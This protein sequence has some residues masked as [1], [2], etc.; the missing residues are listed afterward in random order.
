[1][2]SSWIFHYEFLSSRGN[3]EDFMMIMMMINNL[4]ILNCKLKRGKNSRAEFI[5][6]P[7]LAE[8]KAT[9]TRTHTEWKILNYYAN[10]RKK[11][12]NIFPELFANS[13]SQLFWLIS[14]AWATNTRKISA[15]MVRG[16]FSPAH[17]EQR[18]VEFINGKHMLGW[19]FQIPIQVL[20][21]LLTRQGMSTESAGSLSLIL[22]RF[23]MFMSLFQLQG[24]QC[25][26]ES[27]VCYC[28]NSISWCKN[29]IQRK[30]IGNQF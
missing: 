9:W 13:L 16:D 10:E 22:H 15:S 27:K 18:H 14:I 8:P 19:V 28:S 1:M 4:W 5:F 29:I 6:T 11:K 25:Q 2:V 12:Q 24:L 20:L 7:M 21:T 3:C 23:H 17:W 26:S 30:M